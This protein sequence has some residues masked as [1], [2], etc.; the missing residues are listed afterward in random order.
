MSPAFAKA[1]IGGAIVGA[2]FGGLL[3]ASALDLT[4]KSFAQTTSKPPVQDTRPVADFSNSFVSIA[5]HVTP[6]VVSITTTSEARPMDPRMR[7]RVPPGLEDFFQQFGP[8]HPE[9]RE[10]SG[11][12]FIV[13]KDGY[14]LT[15]NHVV[16]DAD[17]VTVT[18]DDQRVFKAKVIGRDPTT[19]VA[20]IKIESNDLPMVSLGDDN[21]AKVGEWV[22]AI[23][24]PLGL[25]ETVT[26]G[27]LSAKGR[28]GG[29]LRGLLPSKY[30]V[31]DFLQTDAAINPGN[32]GGP[33]VDGH[34][35]VIGINSAI[36]SP[37]GYYSGYGFAI[38][39]TLAKSVMDELIQYGK[40]RRAVI[41]I[42]IAPVDPE[43]AGAAGL[44]S[45]GGAKVGGF[46]PS[47]GSSPAQK[48]GL[49][50]GDII[51]GAD[52]KPVD[53]VSTLQRIIRMHQPG[54]TVTLDVVRFG[55]KK[56]FT[57]HLMQAPSEEQI[58]DAS[59]S[60]VKPPEGAST[61]KLGITVEPV[62]AEFAQTNN[63]TTDD[64]GLQVT[65]VNTNGPARG[66]LQPS[67]VIL[68]VLYPQP[69]R[70]VHTVPELQNALSH[71]KAGDF[72]TLLVCS[73]QPQGP[74]GKRVVS[75]KIGG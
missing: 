15:N 37:T 3:L 52:G 40:V 45:I 58:A 8:Q 59:D 55:D 63:L 51:V 73:P 6:A 21:N 72:V 36:A 41:G 1:R 35:D 68:E 53:R 14:I 43:D 38:P 61:E 4:H 7:G 56:T 13:S 48:A 32:S 75:L 19:D 54:Q 2:F 18:L 28:D 11:S 26:A 10:A 57:V 23:G 49:E 47:D 74:C 39:I 70:D 5:A 44:K 20:V 25:R 29:D 17:R 46:Q 12:G 9:P 62:S 71:T 60:V 31:S 69:K 24:N 22:L 65:D 42:S 50:V 16:A 64:R 27:I 67:D 34:G 33:L 66:K 30:A